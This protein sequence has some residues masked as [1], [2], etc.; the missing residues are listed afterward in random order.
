MKRVVTGLRCE[1][2]RAA[3]RVSD[4]LSWPLAFAAIAATLGDRADEQCWSAGN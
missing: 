1:G 2:E 3:D 4:C